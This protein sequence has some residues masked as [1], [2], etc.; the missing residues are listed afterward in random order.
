MLIPTKQN[1]DYIASYAF[2]NEYVAQGIITQEDLIILEPKEIVE[3][4][5][6]MEKYE[7]MW[8]A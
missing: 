5:K 8:K 2:L 7:K 6:T 4:S 3:L 1:L